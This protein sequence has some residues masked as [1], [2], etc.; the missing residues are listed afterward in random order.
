MNP[1]PCRRYNRRF[2]TAPRGA[3]LR[4]RLVALRFAYVSHVLRESRDHGL[5]LSS[6]VPTGSSDKIKNEPGLFEHTRPAITGNRL[7]TGDDFVDMAGKFP[8]RRAGQVES[9]YGGFGITSRAGQPLMVR[10]LL[11]YKPLF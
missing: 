7:R 3:P 4:A 5:D 10:S 11:L 1:S 8:T 6:T 2:P 9:I